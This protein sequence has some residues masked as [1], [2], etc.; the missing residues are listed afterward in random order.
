M[1]EQAVI[2]LCLLSTTD[3]CTVPS[4][5]PQLAVEKERTTRPFCMTGNIML[6]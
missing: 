3:F 4:E 5:A 6:L 2:S 1:L